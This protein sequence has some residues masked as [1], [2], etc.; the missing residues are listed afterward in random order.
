M[1][2]FGN[3]KDLFGLNKSKKDERAKL[4]G[5]AIAIQNFVKNNYLN[6]ENASMGY[7]NWCVH[8]ATI[9]DSLYTITKD[10]YNAR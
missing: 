1:S 9:A 5:V 8:Y 10:I 6:D 4:N 2:I 7:I 3:L